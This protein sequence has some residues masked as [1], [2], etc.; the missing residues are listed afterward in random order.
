MCAISLRRG[1]VAVVPANCGR[2]GHCTASGLLSRPAWVKIRAG[3]A[4]LIRLGLLLALGGVPGVVS[5]VA[6]NLLY[7]EHDGQFSLVARVDGETPLVVVG[8]ELKA[9][10]K[11]RFALRP[12]ENFA[13]YFVSVRGVKLISRWMDFVRQTKDWN[14]EVDF[15]AE[16]ES[17]YRLRSV[18]TVV[19]I[20][21]EKGDKSLLLR[22]VGDL[23]PREPVKISCHV[24]LDQNLRNFQYHLHVF[25]DGQEVLS[26]QLP[27]GTRKQALTKLALE[28]LAGVA[29]A[30]PQ[31]L[32]SPQPLYP[33]TLVERGISGSATVSFVVTPAGMVSDPVVKEAT[34]PAFGEA[35][36]EAVRESWFLPK[37]VDGRRI[38]SRVS[39]PFTFAPPAKSP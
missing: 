13:P 35:A 17:S 15:Q 18:F 2:I 9:G 3:M 32:V 16:F 24:Q 20:I 33:K 26:S 25:A 30:A 28:R 4:T 8:Q 38:E 11:T 37:V 23:A 34:E 27:K 31:P 10:S 6:Q 19:E 29:N 5:V 1:F 22:E 7:A 14:N 21:G 36:L 39:L 12:V